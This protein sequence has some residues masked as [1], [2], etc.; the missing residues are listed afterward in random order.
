MRQEWEVAGATTMRQ[1][2]RERVSSI[3]SEHRAEPLP[4]ETVA[5]MSEVIEARRRSLVPG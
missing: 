2:A 1:R 3:L 4:G 5:A